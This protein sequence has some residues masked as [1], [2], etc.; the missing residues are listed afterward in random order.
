MF[1]TVV[2][3]V[4]TALSRSPKLTPSQAEVLESRLLDSGFSCVL[5]MPTGSGKTWLA[6]LAIESVLKGGYRAVYLSPLRALASELTDRWQERF[7]AWKVG[8][9]TGDYGKPGRPYPVPFREAQLL[10]MTPERLDACTRAWRS[11]WGWIP[12]VDLVVVDELHLLG[13]PHRGPRL[14]GTISRMR[15]LNPFVRFIGLSATLGNR[16]ELADWLDGVEY[17]SSWRPIPLRWRVVRYQKATD[18][19]ALMAE[20]VG[21]NVQAGGKSLVFVQSRRR[22]EELSRYLQTMGL[23]ARHHHAG[24]TH[25]ERRSVEAGFREHTMDV[26]V[27]TS[28]LEM[29]LN[30]PVRQV[31]LYDLQAFDGVDFRPLSTNSVWQRVGRAGRPG[32]D[33]E[34][35]AVLL[36][37]TWDRQAERYERGK[38]EPIRSGLADPRALAE[39]VVAEVASGLARTWSQLE[40]VF[41]QSLAARQEILPKVSVIIAEMRDAG[42]IQERLD[43][44]VKE[45]R[46]LLR[47]T[48]LG[49][50]AAR[51]FLAPA[52]VLMFRRM[53]ETFDLLTL[54]DLLIIA[55]CSDDCQPILPVD[56]EELDA[57]ACDLAREPSF[58]LQHT[59]A[60]VVETLGVDGKRLLAAIK[61]ALV[62]RAWTRCS[63][64]EEVAE[65]HDCYPFEVARLS[66]A[67]DRL[68]L[69]MAA[70][71]DK[72]EEEE[73]SE[74]LDDED[75]PVQERIRALQRM[76]CTGLDEFAATL[77]LVGGI[78]PKMAKRLQEAGIEDIEDLALAEPAELAEVRGLSKE[79]AKRW[80]AEAEV[81][82]ETRSAYRYRESGPYLDITPPGWPP[83][84]DPYRLRRAL[85]LTVAG[86]DGETHLVTG[87]LEPH[88]VR[89]VDGDLTCD[90][91]DASRGNLCKHRLAVRMQRGDR[92]LHKLARQIGRAP[93]S[94]KID[95]FDLWFGN[96]SI[97]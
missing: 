85:D 94:G 43:E 34:G 41:A 81:V 32:L 73:E 45:P 9:F 70:I 27:A 68:L 25:T 38:F 16:G 37:P 21:R 92:Q 80:I 86:A 18:K 17:V 50:I 28:T 42:M 66:E 11:H 33:D 30:L 64:A 52:T 1:T 35:E 8:V 15:R 7:A 95:L 91:V 26:L 19:P 96:H 20:E 71:P 60:E 93:A 12:E 76:V 31:V 84:V 89:F 77:T 23:R 14:E 6:E 65:Q 55:A 54:L 82:I 59:R 40:R 78:G 51:H 53:L 47:A 46:Y 97:K 10:V 90:C 79:R 13:D 3:I 69:A 74:V 29:G 2:Q 49:R 36:A 24:L 58:L 56:F 87:G 22:A 39:Q 67:M 88:I 83:D 5:Q 48:R 44:N 57:I 61:M 4:F 72:P 63:D 75:M 62:T